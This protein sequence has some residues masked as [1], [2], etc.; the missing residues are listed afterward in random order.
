MS[1]RIHDDLIALSLIPG[2]GH[3]TMA[4]LIE[5]CGTADR[6]LGLSPS[7]IE[8]LDF[9]NRAQAE[10]LAKGPDANAVKEAVWRLKD[11]GGHTVPR[12]DAE[13]PSLLKEISDPPVFL[14]V[15]GDLSEIEPAAAI[16]G[17]RAPSQYGKDTAFTLARDL[18][19]KGITIVSGLA[20]GIDTM[21]HK[22]ALEGISK[23][24]AVLGSGL[25]IIYPP[26]NRG[27]AEKIAGKGALISEYAPGT[28][29]RPEN[30][31]KRNRIVSGMSLCS[32][33]VE[34]TERSGAMITARLA[35]EQGRMCMAV[36]GAVTNMRSK[37]PHRLIRQGAT[38]IEN[39]EDVVEE[40]APHLK[41][42][43]KSEHEENIHP[44]VKLISAMPMSIGE[45][46]S[47]LGM[48]VPDVSRELTVMELKGLVTRTEG[49]RFCLRRGNV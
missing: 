32:I 43:L 24:V 10:S 40:I 36:P 27:L 6:V 9:L 42:M 21:A 3:V 33:I 22:G 18:S 38:L 26:E 48:S 44:A 16:V 35:A 31:P 49:G 25:D 20:R 7:E 12:E 5:R 46:A 2:I 8:L 15:I 1:V 30:F 14:Y 34:A 17:T 47:S 28:G 29:P 13:Y 37:G 19:L 4:R 11:A 39:S 45:I 23:T 41:A